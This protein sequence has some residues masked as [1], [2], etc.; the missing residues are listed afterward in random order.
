MPNE[1]RNASHGTPCDSTAFLF[2]IAIG[3]GLLA[4]ANVGRHKL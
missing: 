4:D 2:S 1:L 3:L